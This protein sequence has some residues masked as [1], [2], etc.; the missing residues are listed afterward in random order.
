MRTRNLYKPGS[1]K[2][3]GL[4]RSRLENF[5][6]CPRCFYIDRRLGVEPPAWPSCWA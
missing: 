3:Y 6:N 2:P 1:G 5:L 4:S